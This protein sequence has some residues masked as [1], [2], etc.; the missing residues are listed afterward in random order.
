MTSNYMLRPAIFF[1][2]FFWT[3]AQLPAQPQ[4]GDLFREY[5][6]VPDM[7]QEEEKFL[8]VGGRLDYKHSEAHFPQ[9]LHHDG[10]LSIPEALDLRYAVRAEMVLELLQSHEDTKGLTVQLNNREWL[11]V[12]DLS[13]LPQP[14]SG[15]MLHAY[16]TL[17]IPLDQLKEGAG[18]TFKLRVDTAQ[19]WNWPQNIFY[20][21]IFRV[22]YDPAKKAHTTAAV[23]G[24]E[25]GAALPE[26]LPLSLAAQAPGE[27][28]RVDYI[29]YYDDFNWEGDGRYR[30]W[31][32]HYHQGRIR[33]HIGSA[34]QAPFEVHWDSGWLPEQTGPVKVAARV[35]GRDGLIYLTPPV[36]D[37]RLD[38]DYKVELCRPYD[39]PKN[40]VTRAGTFQ[41]RFD[42]HGDLAR[43]EAV[44]VAWRSWS[45]CYARGVFI[46]GHQVFDRQEPCYRYAEHQLTLEDPS[47]LR[48][49]PNTIRTG[50][51]PLID[52]QMVHGMEVQYPGI[53]VKVK[54]RPGPVDPIRITEG[55]YEG[56]AHFIVSTPAATYY[57]D[58]AGGGLSRLIDREGK[59]WIAFRR[60]PWD[61]YP[62]SAASAYRGIPNLVYG[63]DDSGAGHPG[64]EQCDSRLDGENAILTT[65]NS[66]QWKWRWQFFEDYATLTVLKTDPDHPYWFLYEGTPGGIF[67]P[68]RQFFGTDLGGPRPEQLDFYGGKKAFE[69]WQWAY[70]GHRNVERLLFIAQHQQDQH[71]DTFSYLGNT[72]DGIN[73]P[74]GMVVF[75]FGRSDGAKPLLTQPNTF[76]LGFLEQGVSNPADHRKVERRIK[77]FME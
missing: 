65:S 61:Q 68:P 67:D 14:Q 9:H 62:A 57:Y 40:W 56:A 39:Q 43:A 19:A 7:V 34:R 25:E 45:P 20:G 33:N 17:P 64:H 3:S 6:W 51:T 63:S 58:K 52:G 73:A 16:P 32:H 37:L 26:M 69:Q 38:R 60:Q 70:F 54:Y 75:G 46:N 15:Y 42:V 48:P 77:A 2:C 5:V 76:T 35:T 66:G 30:Q 27:I 21:F 72:P 31:H 44:Q 8:R 4:P 50:M 12:P 1:W 59:D 24:I 29:G 10:H 22:Y 74:D 28:K 47:I 41:A 55:E 71:S 13:G 23:Q 18:N 36:E 11:P 53:M 49:G